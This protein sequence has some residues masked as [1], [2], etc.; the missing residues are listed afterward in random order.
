MKNFISNLFN[1]KEDV[2]VEKMQLAADLSLFNSVVDTH[3]LALATSQNILGSLHEYLSKVISADLNKDLNLSKE[4]DNLESYISA[5]KA[6]KGDD[7]H[8]NFQRNLAVNSMI[9]I[10]AFLLFPLVQNALHHGYNS[11]EKYPVRIKLNNIGDRIKLEVSNR[12][13]HHLQNQES[14]RLILNFKSRLA[15]L[16]PDNHTLIINSNTMLFKATLIIG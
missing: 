3:L 1:K 15:L 2:D 4:I 7:F 10:P 5:Y 9:N 8:V 13:N 14:T 11:I 16:Y 6:V 12:V